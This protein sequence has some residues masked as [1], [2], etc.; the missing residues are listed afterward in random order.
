MHYFLISAKN[1]DCGYA[2]AVLT[3]TFN[4]CFYQKYE[5]YKIFLSKIF[6]CFGG[7]IISIFE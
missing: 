2:E 1:I 5:K 6:L 4:L 3:R 7:R